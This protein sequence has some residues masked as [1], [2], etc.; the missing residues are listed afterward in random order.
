MF[1]WDD[2][3]TWVNSTPV[4]MSQARSYVA[5]KIGKPFEVTTDQDIWLW[6]M[7]KYIEDQFTYDP[8]SDDAVQDWYRKKGIDKR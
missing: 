7:G 2:P 5:A 1:D 8:F 4:P 3:T 6:R